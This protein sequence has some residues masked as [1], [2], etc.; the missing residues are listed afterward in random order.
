MTQNAGAKFAGICFLKN[1]RIARPNFYKK[2]QQIFA[3]HEEHNE[4]LEELKKLDITDRGEGDPTRL[5]PERYPWTTI[6]GESLW[7]AGVEDALINFKT[8]VVYVALL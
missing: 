8:E 1:Y 3:L 5:G 6:P 7:F 4:I 2:M